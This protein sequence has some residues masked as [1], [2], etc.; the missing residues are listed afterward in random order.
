MQDSIYFRILSQGEYLAPKSKGRQI[1][2]R[3]GGNNQVL[4]VGEPNY[5]GAKAP[6][7]INPA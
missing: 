4:K 6:P 5:K 3:G 7:V 1:K 2:V